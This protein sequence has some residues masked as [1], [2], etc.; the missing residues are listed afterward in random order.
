MCARQRVSVDEMFTMD[1]GGRY[2]FSKGYNP[3]AVWATVAAGVPAIASVLVPKWITVVELAWLADFSW[4]IG[5][6]IGFVAMVLL[7][8]RVPRIMPA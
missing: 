3:N 8:R 4:F 6:G 1:P 2:W 7:E 5:C